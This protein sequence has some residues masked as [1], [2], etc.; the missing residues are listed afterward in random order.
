MFIQQDM[1]SSFK[2][3]KK[4]AASCNYQ[5]SYTLMPRYMYG[6]DDIY[7]VGCMTLLFIYAN[8]IT[9]IIVSTS[10]WPF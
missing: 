10:Y 7:S 9:I 2:R 3:R 4:I 8:A 1:F 5:D 6:E